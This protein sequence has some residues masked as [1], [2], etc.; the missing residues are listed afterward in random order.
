MFLYLSIAS[1]ESSH[2]GVLKSLIDRA[3]QLGSQE[4]V[5]VEVSRVL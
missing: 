2:F 1:S 4:G 5:L 3:G